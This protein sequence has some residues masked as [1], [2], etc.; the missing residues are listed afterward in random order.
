MLVVSY[1]VL[2]RWGETVP[3]EFGPSYWRLNFTTLFLSVN[4]KQTN[5]QIEE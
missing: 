1:F 5:K 2:L 3:L 4:Q